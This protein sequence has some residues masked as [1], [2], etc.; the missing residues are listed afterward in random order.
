MGDDALASEWKNVPVR[1]LA[2]HVE[3]SIVPT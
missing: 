1:R 2:L 3:W